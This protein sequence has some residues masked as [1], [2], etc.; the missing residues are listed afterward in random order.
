MKITTYKVPVKL[1]R[2]NN[3]VQVELDENAKE[4]VRDEQIGED[5]SNIVTLSKQLSDHNE[6]QKTMLA[7]CMNA[8]ETEKETFVQFKYLEQ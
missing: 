3:G 2:D 1:T 5:T 8:D 4:H 6:K 7:A